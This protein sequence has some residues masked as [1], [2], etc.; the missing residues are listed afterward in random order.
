MGDP[1]DKLDVLA[2]S[3]NHQFV[4]DARA[5]SSA[6]CQSHW[7]FLEHASFLHDNQVIP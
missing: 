4:V 7:Y 1:S 3:F 6:F 2:F 5:I